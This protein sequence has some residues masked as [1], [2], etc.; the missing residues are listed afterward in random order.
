ML[1]SWFIFETIQTSEDSG[2]KDPNAINYNPSVDISDP[3]TCEYDD[4]ISLLQQQNQV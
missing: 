3:G 2:C 4:K 1:L